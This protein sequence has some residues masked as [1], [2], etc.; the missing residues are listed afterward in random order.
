M[1]LRWLWFQ[2]HCSYKFEEW[3]PKVSVIVKDHHSGAMQ[4]TKKIFVCM[5]KGVTL[6]KCLVAVASTIKVYYSTFHNQHN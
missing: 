1:K 5:K 2:K 3:I 6:K 4:E